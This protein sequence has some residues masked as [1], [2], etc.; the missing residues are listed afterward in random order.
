MPIPAARTGTPRKAKGWSSTRCPPACLLSRR[1]LAEHRA[2]SQPD[3]GEEA[4]ACA[5]FRRAE[6]DGDDVA[7]LEAAPRPAGAKQL[8]RRAAL[9]GPIRFAA[10]L[11]VDRQEDP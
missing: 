5:V 9:N 1:R 10:L 3:A 8:P 6:V 7:G 2:V 4:G 11:V